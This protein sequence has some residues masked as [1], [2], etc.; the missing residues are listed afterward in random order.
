MDDNPNNTVKIK[1]RGAEFEA[2]G[3]EQ[4]VN[5]RFEA[6]MKFLAQ[7]P[8]EQEPEV[9][10]PEPEGGAGDKAPKANDNGSVSGDEVVTSPPPDESLDALRRRAYRVQGDTLS[11]NVIPQGKTADLDAVILILYGRRSLMSADYTMVSALIDGL[12]QSGLP[13]ER[14]SIVVA[15]NETLVTKAGVKRGT[16]YGLTNRGL[17][18]AEEVLR[19]LLQ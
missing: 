3:S 1:I 18:R 8:A 14:I 9:V 19:D 2:S 17:Q 11:L 5:T 4:S 13:A 10:P 6:F 12:K 7:R 15:G 16:R